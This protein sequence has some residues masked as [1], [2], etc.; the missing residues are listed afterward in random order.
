MERNDFS[1]IS[2]RSPKEHFC[3][4]ISK[5]GH[6]LKRR[7]RLKKLLTDRRADDGQISITIVITCSGELKM[8]VVF[9][10]DLFPF[11]LKLKGDQVERLRWITFSAGRAT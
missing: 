5:S 6:W 7:C 8:A 9:P 4:I 11:T 3:E 2:R 10:M 1:N